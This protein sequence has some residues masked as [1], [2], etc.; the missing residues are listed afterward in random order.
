VA[1]DLK[2]DQLR[3]KSIQQWR[4]T[5]HKQLMQLAKVLHL[6]DSSSNTEQ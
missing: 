6:Q 4:I 1:A 3:D 2:L 5:L